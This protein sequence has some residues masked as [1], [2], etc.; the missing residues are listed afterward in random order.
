MQYA[1]NTNMLLPD[2]FHISVVIVD[3]FPDLRAHLCKEKKLNSRNKYSTLIKL[4]KGSKN[5]ERSQY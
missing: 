3:F 4:Q 2:V 1:Y 5:K